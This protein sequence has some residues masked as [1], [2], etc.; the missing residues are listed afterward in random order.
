MKKITLTICGDGY[1]GKTAITIRLCKSRWSDEYDSTVQDAY[2][3]TRRVEGQDYTVVI[4]DTA[5]QE[6]Y[7]ACWDN[8]HQDSEAFLLVYDITNAKSFYELELLNEKIDEL[9]EARSLEAR[10]G[11]QSNKRWTKSDGPPPPPIKIVLA[12]KCDLQQSRVIGAQEGLRWAREHGCGFMETSAKEDVN[13]N[14][15]L[16]LLIKRAA[17]ARAHARGPLGGRLSPLDIF[18]NTSL[19]SAASSSAPGTR[20]APTAPLTP[21]SHAEDDSDESKGREPARS[22]WAKLW[23][24]MKCWQT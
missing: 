24:K 18:P 17:D 6:E 13:V 14:E 5:G 20:H 15:S 16:N 19:L 8:F 7:R 22:R 9:Y 2:T 12:N 10:L 21:P 11:V 1:T 4:I 23:K 3:L